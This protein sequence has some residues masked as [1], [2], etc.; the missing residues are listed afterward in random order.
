[1]KAFIIVSI[2]S[3]MD[4][5]PPTG[6]STGN[7]MIHVDHLHYTAD[8][9]LSAVAQDVVLVAIPGAFEPAGGQVTVTNSTSEAQA[10]FSGRASG[11]F[12]PV[13]AK[14]GDVLVIGYVQQGLS[15][16]VLKHLD[17][18]LDQVE[19]AVQQSV[20]AWE[21]EEGIVT[22]T[23]DQSMHPTHAIIYNR[24]S[25]ASQ[26]Y[27]APVSEAAIAAAPGET[28]CVF[29]LSEDKARAGTQFCAVAQ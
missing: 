20:K 9:A 5:P 22:V 2:L 6:T 21:Y 18:G 3:C 14:L 1:M 13:P 27:T 15:D 26:S 29:K 10:E 7:G 4:P 16:Q 17:D 24:Q 19:R 11:G 25:G 8:E 12:A 23:L 28:F